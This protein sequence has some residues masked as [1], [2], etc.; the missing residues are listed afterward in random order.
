[1]CRSVHQEGE[2]I[3]GLSILFMVLVKFLD[4]VRSD[5]NS[6]YFICRVV[7]QYGKITVGPSI[8][9]TLLVKLDAMGS[10]EKVCTM[11]IYKLFIVAN[12]LFYGDDSEKLFGRLR[13][14]SQWKYLVVLAMDEG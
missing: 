5:G 6:H 1:M 14:P 9:F 8:S 3:V 12:K 4:C 2:I 13:G 10:A 11:N 7:H